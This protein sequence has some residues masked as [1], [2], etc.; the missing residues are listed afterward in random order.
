MGVSVGV[1]LQAAGLL[2][3]LQAARMQKSAFEAEARSYEESK[4]MA[5]I[6]ASQ[7]EAE[8]RRQLRMQLASL[9]TSMSSQGVALGTSPSVLA[10]KEDEERIAQ[11]DI[12]N[13]K[14]MGLS[15]RRKYEISATGARIGGRAAEVAGFAKTAVGAGSLRV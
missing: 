5:K 14:L 6:E 2:V 1:G 7:Q 8:R 15:N 3:G 13:I 4:E 11:R 9:S 10:L 12:S